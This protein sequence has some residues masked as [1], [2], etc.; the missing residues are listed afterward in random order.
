MQTVNNKKIQHD[1]LGIVKILARSFFIFVVIRTLLTKFL[2]IMHQITQNCLHYGRIIFIYSYTFFLR[3]LKVKHT[4]GPKTNTRE[5]QYIFTK[6]NNNNN[7]QIQI[8]TKQQI[9]LIEPIGYK[10]RPNMI[11]YLFCTNYSFLKDKNWAL[12]N[13]DKQTPSPPPIPSPSS[14]PHPPPSQTT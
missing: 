12:S 6:N 8:D 14:H 5:K 3:S 9:I 10:F 13:A 1:V 7:C 11:H 2:Q 4:R